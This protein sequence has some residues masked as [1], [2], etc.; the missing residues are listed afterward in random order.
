[1]GA[2]AA[3]WFSD[4]LPAG[5]CGW[6]ASTPSTGAC[7]NAAGPARIEAQTAF[8][9][10]FALLVTSTASLAELNRRLQQQGAA[11]VDMQPLPAEPRARRHRRPR[12]GPHR[13][14]EIDTPQGTVQLKLVK[15]CARCTIPDVDPLTGEQG[16]AVV[17]TLAGLPLGPAR[18]RR[19]HLRHERHR[20]QRRRASA[21]RGPD[22]PRPLGILSRR[23]GSGMNSV[24][25]GTGSKRCA[26]QSSWA[27]TMRSLRLETK[28]QTMKRR[29]SGCA[30]DQHHARAR[31]AR[32]Q[33]L[34][35]R[36]AAPPAA[37]AGSACAVERRTAR[38]PYTA[39]ARRPAAAVSAAPARSAMSRYSVGERVATGE[40]A[41]E[42]ARRSA[43]APWRRRLSQRRDRGRRRVREGRL[44]LFVARPAAPPTA[45][46]RGCA[47]S[48]AQVVGRALGVHDAAPGRHPVDG[49]GLDA[50]H[51]AGGVAVQHR[52]F[53]QV[54]HG[55]QADVRVR[56]HVVVV[57]GPR[58]RPGRSGRRTGTA[59]P[60]GA[61]PTAAAGARR[62]RRRDPWRWP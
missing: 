34:L 36:R 58:R 60:P 52:A 31:W 51:R 18:R 35:A 13:P 30:A 1:M 3:Q 33:R 45:A 2:L 37:C 55:R 23:C 14:L 38:P 16:F 11:P 10:G 44:D 4:F 47:A 17:D 54:G 22:L 27:C 28:F 8:A 39:R 43:R 40:A 29:P 42:G 15:P 59:R 61:A 25:P 6:C 49:A 62:S 9:D 7:R 53:E 20:R 21:G 5:R 32:Q 24:S 26:R 56:P 57:A 48:G 50:L 19:R 12:R 41:A 46:G